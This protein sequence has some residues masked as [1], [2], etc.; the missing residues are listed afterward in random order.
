MSISGSKSFLFDGKKGKTQEHSANV[1]S[2]SYL[3]YFHGF[4]SAREERIREGIAS[5]PTRETETR[6][7]R[8]ER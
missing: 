5:S 6:L 3:Q 4:L 2:N 8:T 1:T 7:P